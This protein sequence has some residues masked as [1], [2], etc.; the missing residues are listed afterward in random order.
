MFSLKLKSQ[1]KKEDMI[2]PNWKI[3]QFQCP[4]FEYVF[5]IPLVMIISFFRMSPSSL[6]VFVFQVAAGGGSNLS[7]WRFSPS[8]WCFQLEIFW[9]QFLIWWLESDGVVCFSKGEFFGLLVSLTNVVMKKGCSL[10]KEEETTLWSSLEDYMPPPLSFDMS[11]ATKL[12]KICSWNHE[13]QH[14]GCNMESGSNESK[15]HK[16]NMDE[17]SC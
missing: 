6:V 15:Q 17:V 7:F 11:Q 3:H 5:V 9:I 4:C 10:N 2:F 16:I 1:S 8:R 12:V 13:K 14:K